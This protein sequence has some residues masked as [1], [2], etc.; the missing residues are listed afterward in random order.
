MTTPSPEWIEPLAQADDPDD[1]FD[2]D[3]RIKGSP[4]NAVADAEAAKADG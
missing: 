1:L 4:A 2:E 3:G